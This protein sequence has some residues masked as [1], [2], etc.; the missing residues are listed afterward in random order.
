MSES[1][2]KI[3]ERL[4]IA[5]SVWLD[6][7]DRADGIAHCLADEA[8]QFFR[9]CRFDLETQVTRGAARLLAFDGCENALQ[10]GILLHAAEKLP[11]FGPIDADRHYLRDAC[12]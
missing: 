2:P 9:S 1:S 4:V 7:Q 12:R 6:A 3:G 8:L 11:P 5:Q 10:Q